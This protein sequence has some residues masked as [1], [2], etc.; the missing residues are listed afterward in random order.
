MYFKIIS[1]L[2]SGMPGAVGGLAGLS[3]ARDALGLSL[4]N[5]FVGSADCGSFLL[6]LFDGG[7]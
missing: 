6:F 7:R 5:A 3:K 2:W 1:S 4:K